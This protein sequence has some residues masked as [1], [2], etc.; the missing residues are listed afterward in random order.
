M[1]QET[2]WTAVSDAAHAEWVD[3]E[4][5]QRIEQDTPIGPSECP[6]T[7]RAFYGNM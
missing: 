7:G 5:R 3:A 4:Q 2:D 1:T 6:V